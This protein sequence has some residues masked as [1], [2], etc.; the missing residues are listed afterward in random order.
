MR[1]HNEVECRRMYQNEMD[2]IFTEP[3]EDAKA[4]LDEVNAKLEKDMN[5]IVDFGGGDKP[6]AGLPFPF[7]PGQV[8]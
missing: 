3:Y 2:L 1:F 4:R 5:E 7:K 6:Y 8:I